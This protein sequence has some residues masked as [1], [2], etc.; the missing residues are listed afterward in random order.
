MNNN[1]IIRPKKVGFSSISIYT[2]RC[3]IFV[4]NH[5]KAYRTFS[6]ISIGCPSLSGSDYCATDPCLNGATCRNGHTTYHCDCAKTHFEGPRCND[7]PAVYSFARRHGDAPR[8]RLPKQKLSQSEDVEIKFRTEDLSAVLIDTGSFNASDRFRLSL[9]HGR[10]QLR[11][12]I[13]GMRQSFGWGEG[14]N[15]NQWHTVRVSRRGEKLRLFVDGK[16]E[17]HCKF[18][19]QEEFRFSRQNSAFRAATPSSRRDLNF[20]PKHSC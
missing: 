13:D 7:E 16:W 10:L 6:E 8:I 5:L 4:G 20:Q 17:N 9:D 1:L 3:E 2:F 19:F 11:L 14:L 12:S 18:F 15:D